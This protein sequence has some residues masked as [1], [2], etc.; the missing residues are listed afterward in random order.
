M[1]STTT[2]MSRSGGSNPSTY[3]DSLSFQVLVTP[4]GGGSYPTM[5]GT[6]T[7][8]SNGTAVASASVTWF[9]G[10]KI[11]QATIIINN[12]SVGTDSLVANYGG[13]SNYSSSSSTARIKPSTRRPSL[14]LPQPIPVLLRCGAK[15]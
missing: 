8:D 2:T 9:S 5:T 14:P 11:G 10:P 1:Y 13:D 3:G 7:L 15:R 12:L 6:I 4:S